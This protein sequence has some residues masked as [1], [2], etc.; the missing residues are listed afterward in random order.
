MEKTKFPQ[1]KMF[2]HFSPLQSDENFQAAVLFDRDCRIENLF[3]FDKRRRRQFFA[4][5]KFLFRR[6]AKI[7]RAEATPTAARPVDEWRMAGL[8]TSVFFQLKKNSER[9]ESFADDPRD[10]LNPAARKL[11]RADESR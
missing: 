4:G 2:L 6:K 10:C 3:G 1:Q 5:D 11:F 9:R 7:I 8:D